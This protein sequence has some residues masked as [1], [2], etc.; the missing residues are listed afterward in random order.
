MKRICTILIAMTVA[1]AL[2]ACIDI[3]GIT[4]M[5]DTDDVAGIIGEISEGNG[6]PAGIEGLLTDFTGLADLT[7]EQLN[8]ICSSAAENGYEV[9]VSEDGTAVFTDSEGNQTIMNHN[10]T[11]T[12]NGNDAG[13]N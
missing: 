5:I 8:Q 10:G 11:W 4:D 1:A 6:I 2:C 12:V 3:D 9:S 7:D 13:Q